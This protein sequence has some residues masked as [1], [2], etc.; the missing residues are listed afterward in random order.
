MGA[1]AGM[2]LLKKNNGKKAQEHQLIKQFY[3]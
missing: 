3:F 2:N 1:G